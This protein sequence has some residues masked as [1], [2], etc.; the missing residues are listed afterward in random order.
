MFY[1][2]MHFLVVKV[3]LKVIRYDRSFIVSSRSIQR[4]LDILWL[5]SYFSSFS[6]EVQALTRREFDAIST[7]LYDA[8][9]LLIFL[10][11]A[12]TSQHGSLLA[13][14][15]THFTPRPIR[16]RFIDCLL[17]LSMLVSLASNSILA[18]WSWTQLFFIAIFP[19]KKATFLFPLSHLRS[20]RMLVLR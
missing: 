2:K 16:S 10:S 11:L 18:K 1:S 7:S 19:T 6:P 20:W 12:S 17:N 8:H 13:F 14:S 15:L 3:T 9:H 5:E 4:V